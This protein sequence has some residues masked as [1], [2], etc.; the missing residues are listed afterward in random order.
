[1]MSSLLDIQNGID[2][3]NYKYIFLN[4]ALD[5]SSYPKD[6]HILIRNFIVNQYYD[7]KDKKIYFDYSSKEKLF[8]IEY[9]LKV[10]LN[11]IKYNIRIYAIIPETFPDNNPEFYIKHLPNIAVIKGYIK[12]NIINERTL[13]IN[14]EKFF[15]QKD[16]DIDNIISIMNAKFNEY[17]PIYKETNIKQCQIIPGKNNFDTIDLKEIIINKSRDLN[18]II[19]KSQDKLIFQQ[20][21]KI[22]NELKM[23]ITQLNKQ[24]IDEKYK[25]KRL[26]KVNEQLNKIIDKDLQDLKKI[27]EKKEKNLMKFK[28]MIVI[29]IL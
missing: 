8:I 12:S 25:N 3:K 9:L 28:I 13:K 14:I 11:E 4:E 29:I 20:I 10:Y 15:I 21:L 16:Y 7:K 2:D 1:M 22:N 23:E 17:F 18:E 5:K 26:I 6:K 27:K 24:L 19:N